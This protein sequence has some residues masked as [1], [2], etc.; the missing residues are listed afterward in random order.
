MQDQEAAHNMV[1][2]GGKLDGILSKAIQMFKYGDSTGRR[3]T[4]E[5]I[6]PILLLFYET[7]PSRSIKKGVMLKYLEAKFNDHS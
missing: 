1:L 5:H 2:E 6:K 3:S 7:N 4:K